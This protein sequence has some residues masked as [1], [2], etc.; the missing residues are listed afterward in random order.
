MVSTSEKHGAGKREVP[1]TTIRSVDK[2]VD[3]LEVLG[4]ESRGLPL[5]ELARR[6]NLNASTAHHL[7]AT[8]KARG[9]VVQDDRTKAYRIGYRLVALVNHFLADTDLYSAGIGPVEELRDLAGE[10]S[11]LSVFQGHDV[12]V[13]ISLT[14]GRP[15][16]A[17]RMQRANQA[18]LHS[19]ATGKLLLASRPQAEAAA[20][21]QSQKLAAFT[22]RTITDPGVLMA[23]LAQ[24]RQQGYALDSEE[25]YIGLECIAAPVYDAAGETIASVSISYPAA[26]PERT[27]GLIGLVREAAT[28]I[29]ANL[30][31]GPRRATL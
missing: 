26:S 6:L 9:L 30:G 17:R 18:N 10:T 31:A 22:P 1:S 14:G 2:V 5:G 20:L 28:K 4:R 15:I 19:T 27:Q 21:L 24:I 11:Y 23:A 12:A 3:I 13:I 25:D 16:Q 7:L 29:S 8:L